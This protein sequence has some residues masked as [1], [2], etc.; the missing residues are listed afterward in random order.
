MSAAT[1]RRFCQ[2]GAAYTG[3]GVPSSAAERIGAH[4]DE[5]HAGAGP[6][7]ATEQ[8]ARSARRRADR[9]EERERDAELRAEVDL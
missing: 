6:G 9:A 2:C 4:F 8:D 3:T 5:V 1:V 7:P